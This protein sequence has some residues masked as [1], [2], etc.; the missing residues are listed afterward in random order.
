MKENER[1]TNRQLLAI[2]QIIASSTLEEARKKARI[3][4]GTLYTWLKD[5]AFKAELKRERDEVVNEALSR[6]K[7]AITKAVD[8]LIKLMDSQRPDLRRWVFKDIIDYTLKSIE[9]EDIEERLDKI[10][11]HIFTKE[12]A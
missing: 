11:K 8:G 7:K 2:N 12:K 4:K 10:E 3:S 6:L 1:L 9:I 5:E